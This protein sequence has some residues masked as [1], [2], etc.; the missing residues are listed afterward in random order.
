VPDAWVDSLALGRPVPDRIRARVDRLKERVAELDRRHRPIPMT[1]P[2]SQEPL[3]Y[4]HYGDPPILATLRWVPWVS[5]GGLALLLSL[6]WWGLTGIRRAERR[7]IW[8]GMALET[9]H[10]LGTPLSS[11][12][13]WV[14][15]L[16]SRADEA[17][18]DVV[19]VSR[20]EMVETLDEME[21]DVDRLTKVAQRFSHV[22]S[23]PQLE[24]QDVAS[25]VR[26][27]VGYA[28]PRLPRADG[29]V[30]I[31]EHYQDAAPLP[32]NP[33]LLEWVIENLLTNAISALD[34]RPGR[35]RVAVAPD[36]E[37]GGVAIEVEDNGRGMSPT[38]QRRAFEPGY[39]TKRRGWGLGLA[40]S[41]RVVEE[42]HLGRLFIRRS[43]P[44]EGTV[45]VV[46]LPR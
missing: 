14:E 33:E 37:T 42:Y 44:G 26:A 1:R 15:R 45:V 31:E 22:G 10:Q 43:L 13:G 2:I 9:A 5:V 17:P 12:M 16:R 18:D 29:E 21:R 3:G 23:A 36:R 35:I 20:A 41:R 32:C 28:R 6:G 34:K 25:V 19:R 30:V 4:L 40:L 24:S 38:E 8:V 46:L 11:L 39:T 7:S 27:A